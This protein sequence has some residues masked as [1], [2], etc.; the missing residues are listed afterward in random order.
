MVNP[1]TTLPHPLNAAEE[2]FVEQMAQGNSCVFS[3]IRPGTDSENAHTIRAEVIKFFALGGDQYAK[4]KGSN[5]H[6]EG[7]RVSGRLDLESANIPY[8]L[9]LANCYFDDAVVLRHAECR[10]VSFHG[11][12]LAVGLI[13]DGIK[14]N[15]ALIMRECFAGGEIRLIG[16]NIGVAFECSGSIFKNLG[17]NALYAEKAKI[18]GNA[19]MR[20]IRAEGAIA[21]HG[22]SID[23]NLDCDGSVLRNKGGAATALNISGASIGGH[24]FLRN[25]FFAEG[26]VNLSGANV[27]GDVSCDG[28]KM[29]N[30]EASALNA[31]MATIGGHMLLRNGFSAEGEVFLLNANIRG[32]L[33]CGGGA[34]KGVGNMSAIAADGVK[35]AK[36]CFMGD[37]FYAKGGVRLSGANIGGNLEYDGG[38][39]D[40]KGGGYDG[41][42]AIVANDIKVQ[43]NVFMRGEF[44]AEAAVDFSRAHI[45]GDL[46]CDGGRFRGAGRDPL[47][48]QQAKIGG[49]VSLGRDFEAWGTVDL[50][51][52]NI[53][54]GLYCHDGQFDGGASAINAD[55]IR[56]GEDVEFRLG[57][58]ADGVVCL[59]HAEI[60]KNLRCDDSTFNGGLE[61][62]G[63]KVVDTFCWKNVDGHG[64]VNLK[65]ASAKILDDD[66][67]SREG[68]GFNLFGFSYSQLADY[69]HIKSRI[70]W[71][72]APKG[73]GYSPQPFE[74]AAK[75]F[76]QV[77]HDIEA[78]EVLLAKEK[79]L[80]ERGNMSGMR[81]FLR[82]WW[83]RLAGYGYQLRKTLAWSVGIIIFGAVAFRFADSNC[84][85]VPSQPAVV[86]NKE[87][88]AEKT[89]ECA[90]KRAPTEA[91]KRL[92]PDYVEFQPLA[93]SVDVFFPFFALHQ[94]PYWE[95]KSE[96]EFTDIGLYFLRL[97]FWL[98]VAAGWLLTSLAVL[99]ITGLLRP[100]QSS[101]K[102]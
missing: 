81:R 33:L 3:H 82:R 75:V 22:A 84:Y 15:G 93:Y 86:V 74:Q 72:Q 21:L 54:G 30:M 35:I 37:G 99:S 4:A 62:E 100:R 10:L 48:V 9:R 96:D 70:K 61:A 18:G 29:K 89:H 2:T 43:G 32:N 17:G 27:G 63:M 47:T 20:N 88:R 26:K 95:P 50:I 14:V 57:F 92:F 45:S 41:G 44:R 91:V 56:V 5:I 80:T 6:L 55:R 8:A 13:A 97:W 76:F 12:R 77:G 85:I 31:E 51:G 53:V 65:F 11:S 52:A 36:H 78:R 58:R 94:E 25:G 19:L 38:M 34:F 102:E 28:G 7:V 67:K 16:A 69:S 66:N 87:Y 42:F 79:L 64:E 59:P 68:F 90:T 60:R 39:V 40:N 24:I 23:G 101:G 46:N 73:V 71:L 1:L 98:E 49:N 83:D